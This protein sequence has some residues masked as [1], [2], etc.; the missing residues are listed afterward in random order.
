MAD[1]NKTPRNRKPIR[2]NFGV[3]WIYI[4][5]MIGIGWMFFNQGGPNPQKIEWPEVK[6]MWLDGDI[7]EIVFMKNSYNGQITMQPDRI[8]KYADKYTCM[9]VLFF[10]EW[11]PVRFIFSILFKFF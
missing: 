10:P 11:F 2:I 5:L 9:L 8:E 6:Q 7:K 1:N 3:S 4:I